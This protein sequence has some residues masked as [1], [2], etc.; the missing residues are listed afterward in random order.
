MNFLVLDA[1]SAK[2]D[3]FGKFPF[4]IVL[5]LFETSFGFRPMLCETHTGKPAKMISTDLNLFDIMLK[6]FH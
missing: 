2:S 4:Q 1:V 6:L 3:V 5:S